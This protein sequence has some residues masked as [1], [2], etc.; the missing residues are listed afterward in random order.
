M[1]NV[2]NSKPILRLKFGIQYLYFFNQI[3]LNPP[4]YYKLAL[5]ITFDFIIF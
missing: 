2:F 3:S 4:K 5:V 1:F